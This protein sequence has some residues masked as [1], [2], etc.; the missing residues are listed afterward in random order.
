M[1]NNRW[2]IT[3]NWRL[4]IYRKRGSRGSGDGQFR[5]PHTIA[6][7]REGNAYVTDTGNSRVEK[8]SADGK[9]ITKWGSKGSAEGSFNEPHNTP[10]DSRGNVYVSDMFNHRIQKFSSE[11]K[12][13]TQWDRKDPEKGYF[14]SLLVSP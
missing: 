8:F 5:T 2:W 3:F 11:G 9:F 1:L 13:I 14:Y 6:F 10:I 4:C 7:D 12:Y